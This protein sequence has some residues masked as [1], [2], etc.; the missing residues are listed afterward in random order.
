LTEAEAAAETECVGEVL[1]V[2][3]LEP[4]SRTACMKAAVPIMLMC[5]VTGVG[6]EVCFGNEEARKDGMGAGGT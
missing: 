2:K 3:A 5:G 1:S 6:A 4:G